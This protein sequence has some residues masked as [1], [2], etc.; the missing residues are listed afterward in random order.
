MEPTRIEDF[1]EDDRQSF[2]GLTNI[3]VFDSP[4][5]A[6]LRTRIRELHLAVTAYMREC[7]RALVPV[8]EQISKTH[9]ALR[10]AKVIDAQ[11]RPIS[12]P[13]RPAWQSTYGPP[14]RRRTR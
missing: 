1:A 14:A 11:G 7:A 3:V 12:R 4:E 9:E 2:H 10:E 8:M 13:D 6:R 5:F